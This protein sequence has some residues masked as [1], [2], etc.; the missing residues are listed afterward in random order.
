MSAATPKRVKNER[1][2]VPL[3]V[4]V[5]FAGSRVLLNPNAPANVDAAGFHDAVQRRLT[6]RLGQLRAELGLTDRHFFCGLSQLAIGADTLFTRTCA[7]LNWP[8][9]FFLPQQREDFLNAAGSSGTPDFTPGQREVARALFDSPH[10]VQER[11]VSDSTDR[12]TRFQ[13]VNLELVRVSDVLVCLMRAGADTQ[14]GGTGDL[15]AEASRRQRPLLEIQVDVG[16]DGQPAFSEEWHHK[17]R[18]AE[19]AILGKPQA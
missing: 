14:P 6:T 19:T 12:E 18:F 2:G 13:D 4:Q 1:P 15:M 7:D 10:V 17:E 5:G 11:V 8:Q 9:R 3:V 16:S